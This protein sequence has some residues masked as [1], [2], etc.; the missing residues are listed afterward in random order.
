MNEAEISFIAKMSD[1]ISRGADFQSFSRRNLPDF[2]GEGCSEVLCGWMGGT[3][4]KSPE[5]FASKLT[6][7]FGM[8]S[9]VIFKELENR[10]EEQL[11]RILVTSPERV[12]SARNRIIQR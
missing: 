3:A 10:A 4:M 12:H 1:F 9:A 8:G 11:Q 5:V 6:R 7:I 2:L